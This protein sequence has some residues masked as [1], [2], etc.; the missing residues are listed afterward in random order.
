MYFEGLP[1]PAGHTLRYTGNKHCVSC[2]RK[3]ALVES[4]RRYELDPQAS[5]EKSRARKLLAGT[6]RRRFEW[7]PKPL[8]DRDGYLSVSLGGAKYK[9]H[10][11][12]EENRI[13]RR[14]L[15]H[16]TVHHINGDRTD[17]RPTNLEL[18]SSRQPP[19]QRV[20]DKVKWARELLAQYA[21]AP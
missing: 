5:I 6:Q 9:V 10:R 4:R 7:P 18:W 1:C 2:A 11:V 17:N 13:G 21:C 14:L 8:L 12:I 15:R 20:A 19:G 3:R 16:E